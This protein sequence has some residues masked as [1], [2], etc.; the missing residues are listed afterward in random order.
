ME[1]FL[2]HLLHMKI[3]DCNDNFCNVIVSSNSHNACIK[4]YF[5]D[6][7]VV[8]EEG[9]E[10]NNMLVANVEQLRKILINKKESSFFKGFELEF[11]LMENKPVTTFQDR[12]KTIVLDRRGGKYF[13]NLLEKSE[14]D[15]VEAYTD[16]S[17]SSKTRKGGYV[18]LIKDIQGDYKMRK[19]KSKASKS[20]LLELQ[21]AIKAMELLKDFEKFR[22]FTDSVYVIKGISEW[23]PMW[24]L[25]SWLTC[26]G[27]EVKNIYHWK[28]ADLLSKN[29]YIEFK[30]IKGH[31]G[32]FENTICDL[33][34]K[35]ISKG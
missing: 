17:Y 18:I 28:K 23:L 5:K 7:K 9:G 22:I 10:L 6:K 27:E 21:A 31:S 13:F 3:V 32:H 25:N 34:A 1:K 35:D 15:L 24:K 14:L 19:Y 4:Y 16:A 20:S 12:N 30:W 26:N 29:K 11:V 33:Y 2:N 8:V